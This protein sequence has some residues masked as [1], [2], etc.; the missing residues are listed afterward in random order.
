MIITRPGKCRYGIPSHTVPLRALRLVTG[1]TTVYQIL[2]GHYG[3]QLDAAFCIIDNSRTRGHAHKSLKPHCTIDATKYFFLYPCYQYLQ[4]LARDGGPFWP[5]CPPLNATFP[6]LTCLVIHSNI[7]LYQIFLL[8]ASI[9]YSFVSVVFF[10]QFI[11]V[12]YTG[13]FCAKH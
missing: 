8:T 6:F 10:N 1:L 9:L 5:H 12:S 7:S 2:H 3:T 13:S 4:Q 11:G